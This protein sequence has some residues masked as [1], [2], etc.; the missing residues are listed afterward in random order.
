MRSIHDAKQRCIGFVMARGRTGF[1]AFDADE[2]GLG[3][4]PT[5]QDAV[6]AVLVAA[7]RSS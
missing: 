4:F 5:S 7:E 2:R 3:R 6:D 1:E